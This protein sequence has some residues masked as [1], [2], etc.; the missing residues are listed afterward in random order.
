MKKLLLLLA[1]I[2]IMTTAGTAA[3]AQG[4]SYN[5]GDNMLNIGIGVG[6]PFFGS[7]YSSSLPVNPSL[8]FEHGVSDVISIGGQ[9]S[10]ASAKYSY[11]YGIYADASSFKESA[12][13]VGLRGSYHF[14]EALQ[15]DDKWDFYGGA[16]LG[17]VIVSVSDY[18]G[19]G[20]SASASALGFGLYGGG[21]YYFGEKMALYS[22][23]GYQSLALLNVGISFKF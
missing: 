12:T 21:K 15:L 18:S 2:V 1:A 5:K 14:N 13:Y 19:Y 4:G 22:E 6:S 8:S 10:Y 9:L 17:Y 16:S 3:F 11:D 20:G 23:L 7:G